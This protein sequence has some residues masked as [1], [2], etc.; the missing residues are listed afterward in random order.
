[1]HHT[2]FTPKAG[3]FLSRMGV[4]FVVHPGDKPLVIG[5]ISRVAKNRFQWV[6]YVKP[7]LTTTTMKTEPAIAEKQHVPKMHTAIWAV[8]LSHQNATS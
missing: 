1:M 7:V 6:R 2:P 5:R 4:H 3:S 8:R